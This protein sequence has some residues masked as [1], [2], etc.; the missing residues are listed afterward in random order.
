MSGTLMRTDRMLFSLLVVLAACGRSTVPG[1][2]A[3]AKPQSPANC[4][5]RFDSEGLCGEITW[6]V[7]PTS[8]KM[9]AFTLTFWNREPGPEAGWVDPKSEVTSFIRM[10]CCGSVSANQVK[11]TV[12]GTYEVTNIR[13]L[14]GDWEVYVQLKKGTAVEKQFIKVTVE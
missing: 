6:T 9:S 10:K 4:P 2:S 8:E 7:G 3:A 13:F 11:H 14:P 12:Q 5:F 1:D